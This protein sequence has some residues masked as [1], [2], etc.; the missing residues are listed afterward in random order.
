MV[1][2]IIGD[3]R[4]KEKETAEDTDEA[5]YTTDDVNESFGQVESQGETAHDTDDLNDS[6]EQF[7]SQ[8]EICSVEDTE[9]QLGSNIQTRVDYAE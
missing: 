8:G 4:V 7:E 2:E 6:L 5:D 9:D 1:T 3:L